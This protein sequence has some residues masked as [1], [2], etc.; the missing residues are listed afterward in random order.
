MEN[1]QAQ[2]IRRYNA[3]R[4]FLSRV[5]PTF[6]ICEEESPIF[7]NGPAQT[8]AKHVAQKFRARHFLLAYFRRPGK[9]SKIIWAKNARPVIKKTIRRKDCVAMKLVKGAVP[10]VS[11]G[12]YD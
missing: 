9:D 10:F 11:T 4:T 12:L 5:A 3:N 1:S 6:I 7:D 8:T 2:I